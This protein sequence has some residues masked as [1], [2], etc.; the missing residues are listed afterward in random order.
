MN[1]NPDNKSDVDN[2]ENQELS[3]V[4]LTNLASPSTTSNGLSVD[5]KATQENT[6]TKSMLLITKNMRNYLVN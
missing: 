2:Y 5:G 6:T 3:F 1:N 4:K